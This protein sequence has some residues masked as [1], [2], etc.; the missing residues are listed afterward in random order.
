MSPRAS[1]SIPTSLRQA[2]EADRR[3][4]QRY[5]QM[6]VER[7]AEL[8]DTTPGNLYKQMEDGTMHAARLAGW[9]HDTGGKAVISLLA[10][11]AGGVF[12]PI[13]LGRKVGPDDIQALQGALNQAVGALLA[14]HA[15]RLEAEDCQ[16]ALWGGM[17]G[18][19]WHR[20]NVS[21]ADQPELDLGAGA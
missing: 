17:A 10:A 18:L 2:F 14:F 12:I 1:N 3:H 7:L 16:A 21:K 5:R 6:S 11:Q 9:F 8:R 19:A 4:A 13:A 15:G 20:E